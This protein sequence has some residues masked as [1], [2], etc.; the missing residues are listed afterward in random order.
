M[1]ED[2]ALLQDF[3]ASQRK[4]AR[5]AVA[6]V[7]LGIAGFAALKLYQSYLRADSSARIEALQQGRILEQ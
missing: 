2:E 5:I 3:Q 7:A 4:K 1:S 6:V